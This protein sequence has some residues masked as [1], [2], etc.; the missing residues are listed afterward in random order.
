MNSLRGRRASLKSS[1]FYGNALFWIISFGPV[2]L[3]GLVYASLL[4]HTLSC[5]VRQAGFGLLSAWEASVGSKFHVGEKRFGMGNL[6]QCCC[7]SRGEMT[8]L[9]HSLSYCP[10]YELGDNQGNLFVSHLSLKLEGQKRI[11]S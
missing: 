8:F 3:F 5:T 7:R 6:A 1:C 9:F 4:S 11:R 2:F 10:G